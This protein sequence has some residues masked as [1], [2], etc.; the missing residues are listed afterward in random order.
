[1]L[2]GILVKSMMKFLTCR[3]KMF[4][5]PKLSFKSPLITPNPVKLAVAFRVGGQFALPIIWV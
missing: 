3:Q 4:V 2:A 5:V 1:M